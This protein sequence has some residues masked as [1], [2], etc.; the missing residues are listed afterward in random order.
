VILKDSQAMCLDDRMVEARIM[1]DA[2]ISMKY[3]P[4]Q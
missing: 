4:D 3:V 2:G 1:K